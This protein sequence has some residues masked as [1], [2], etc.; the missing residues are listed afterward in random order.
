M[1]KSVRISIPHELSPAEVK[2]RLVEAIADARAKHGEL[3]REAH[4]EWPSDDRMHFTAQAMGQRISGSVHIEQ[5]QV[6]V[7]VMLPMLL[8][9]FAS[10]LTPRIEDE[11]RK[12]LGTI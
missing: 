9:M 3:L 7:T 4:E 5:T 2:R 12:L 6:H 10:K 1:A 11:A 8:A